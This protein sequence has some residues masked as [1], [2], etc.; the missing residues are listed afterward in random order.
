MSI[1]LLGKP[2]TVFDWQDGTPCGETDPDVF[3]GPDKEAEPAR[4]KREAQAKAICAGCR[5]RRPCLDYAIA[6]NLRQGVF[7]GLGEDERRVYRYNLRRR[8]LAAEAR[9]A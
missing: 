2:G 9:E 7:G 3:F 8:A 4:D 6:R 1:A 5:S